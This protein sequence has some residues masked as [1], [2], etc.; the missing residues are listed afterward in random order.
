MILASHSGGVSDGGHSS[1]VMKK[2]RPDCSDQ[3]WRWNP[4]FRK[5]AKGGAPKLCHQRQCEKPANESN[6]TTIVRPMRMVQQL[7]PEPA[8]ISIS[9]M[10]TSAIAG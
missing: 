1:D 2:E 8:M 5:S 10:V 7:I 6:K 9:I 4:T 3:T